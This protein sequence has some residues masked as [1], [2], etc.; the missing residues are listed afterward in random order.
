MSSNDTSN[1]TATEAFAYSQAAESSCCRGNTRISRWGCTVQHELIY[2]EYI[3]V[4]TSIVLVQIRG[5]HVRKTFHQFSPHTV[6]WSTP[7]S[8]GE[9]S[10]VWSWRDRTS[11]LAECYIKEPLAR[12]TA[13][14]ERLRQNWWEVDQKSISH[15]SFK[16]HLCLLL[17]CL[18]TTS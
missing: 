2:T 7:R 12:K 1:L 6:L 10:P 5:A 17:I 13:C 18:P 4:S 8:R 9:S 15:S 11:L 14:W 3:R 16:Y